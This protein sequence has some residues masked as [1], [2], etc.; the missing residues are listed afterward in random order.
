MLGSMNPHLVKWDNYNYHLGKGFL[1]GDGAA[2]VKH[3]GTFWSCS[4]ALSTS[5]FFC[6]LLNGN[7]EVS[8]PCG[9]VAFGSLAPEITVS[10]VYSQNI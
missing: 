8:H 4:S 2:P 9:G 5:F 1:H 10:G 3:K 7:C 6:F